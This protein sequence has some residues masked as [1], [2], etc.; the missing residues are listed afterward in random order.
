MATTPMPMPGADVAGA[1]G[2]PGGTGQQAPPP[3]TPEHAAFQFA[4]AV[5][6]GDFD[7]VEPYISAKALGQL[8]DLRT[9]TLADSKKQDLKDKFGKL[10]LT[11]TKG[12]SGGKQLS[13]RSGNTLI[14]LTVKKEGE[15]YKVAEM[16][17]REVGKR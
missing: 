10:Q 12:V 15:D 17:L 5:A 1:P 4:T 9:K 14:T 6:K 16:Q 8:K 3:G 11:A 2:A 7:S 13:L